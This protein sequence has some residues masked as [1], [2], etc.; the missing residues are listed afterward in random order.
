TIAMR[1]VMAGQKPRWIDALAIV[2]GLVVFPHFDRM[3][4]FLDSSELRLLITDLPDGILV[5]GID[6]NT[7]LVRLQVDANKARWRV[8]GQQAVHLFEKN[9]PDRTLQVGE[10][11]VLLSS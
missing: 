5:V 4:R 6:E 1:Q 8:M 2:P 7:A 3:S 9:A 10:E 11:V